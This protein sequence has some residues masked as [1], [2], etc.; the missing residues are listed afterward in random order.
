MAAPAIATS[1]PFYGATDTP[2]L[3]LPTGVASGDLLIAVLSLNA[4]RTI[5]A[6]AG[7]TVE[8]EDVDPVFSG[9]KGVYSRVAD[10]SEGSSAVWTLSVGA[11]TAALMLRITGADTS[12][13][14]TA[15]TT[16]PANSATSPSVT[17]TAADS[18]VLRLIGQSRDRTYTAPSGHTTAIQQGGNPSVG[19][20][21]IAQATAGASGTAVWTIGGGGADSIVHFTLA[22]APPSGGPSVS[23][24]ALYYA[25]NRR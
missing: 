25:V 2:T 6:P 13:P 5:T 23:I 22:I 20:C 14:V 21:S 15:I 19:A 10:G 18:L 24:P 4:N 11:T 3:N 1:A 8:S 9:R 17:T 12:D 7:W 16:E